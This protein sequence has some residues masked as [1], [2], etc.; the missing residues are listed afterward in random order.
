M[1]TAKNAVLSLSK[2][3]DER[4]SSSSLVSVFRNLLVLRF[5]ASILRSNALT[6]IRRFGIFQVV[7]G[8]VESLRV[9][10]F[11]LL[12]KYVPAV[13]NEV[14]SAIAKNIADIDSGFSHPSASE[15]H[16]K[17]PQSGLSKKE[18]SQALVKYKEMD[19]IDYAAGR[20]TAAVFHEKAEL[21]EVGLEAISRYFSSNVGALNLCGYSLSDL[22]LSGFRR[23]S[24]R[25]VSRPCTPTSSNPLAKWKLK[26][27]RWSST[28]S[29][30]PPQ[31]AEST[32][33]AAPSLSPWPSKLT[34]T[35]PEQNA[36]SRNRN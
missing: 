20:V 26:S 36:E 32:P 24:P 34:V 8:F 15:V 6:D 17:L 13:R 16:L 19:H 29:T 7:K 21:V 9:S 35:K 27:S 10:G 3:V 33:P 2:R 4:I 28:C 23:L 18:V 22:T 11:S 5:I 25:L 12:R 30:R 14:D 31:A 1:E